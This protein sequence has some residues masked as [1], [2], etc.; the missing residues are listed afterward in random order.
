MPKANVWL[1]EHQHEVWRTY[2]RMRTRLAMALSQSLQQDSGM[3]ESDYAVLVALS[4]TPGG[5]MRALNLRCELQWEKSRLAHHVRRMEQRGLVL[6]EECAEDSRAPMVRITEAGLDSIRAAAPA[7]VARVRELFVEALT[8]GQLDA[9]HE[10]SRAILK[11][12]DERCP[13]ET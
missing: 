2:L 3:S 7:H 9:L 10:A 12:L 6:R 4:E 8:P 13:S 1:D 5:V 11:R